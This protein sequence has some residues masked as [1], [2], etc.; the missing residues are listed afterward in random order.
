M[1]RNS[2]N[3]LYRKV[4]ERYVNLSTRA[5]VCQAVF[6]EGGLTKDGALR[7][8]RLGFLDY[9]LRDYH[10]HSDKDIVF[11]PVGINYDRVIED[12]SLIRRLD[13]SVE[14]RSMWFVMK[15]TLGFI[16]KNA[17]LSRKNRWRRFGY[18]SVNFGEPVSA[19]K[20]CKEHDVDFSALETEQRFLRVGA[21]AD[22]IM[23]NITQVVPVVPV[24]LMSEILIKN[25][26]EWKSEL[27]LKSQCSER[28]AQLEKAGAPID[29]SSSALES[30]L[31]S[32]LDALIGRG[33]IEEKDNLYR[34]KKA[35]TDILTYYANS[36]AHWQ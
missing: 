18:A 31:G 4:L 30:V 34:M 27:E 35:E 21:L 32:A 26:S 6:L 20:Y 15:T 1:R 7:D 28:I 14:N 16:F 33:L 23:K 36:I 2:G 5:G 17:L 12:R 3:P 11:V 8:P 25:T 22:S 19:K 13:K 9:M 24:A 29:I 10:Q